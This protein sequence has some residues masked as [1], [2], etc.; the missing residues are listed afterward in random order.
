M[1]STLTCACLWPENFIIFIIKVHAI[2]KNVT[3]ATI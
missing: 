2:Y 3:Q 1:E